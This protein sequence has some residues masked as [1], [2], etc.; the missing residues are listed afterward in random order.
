MPNIDFYL[1]YALYRECRI[2]SIIDPAGFVI[3]RLIMW[4]YS[5]WQLLTVNHRSI[6]HILPSFKCDTPWVSGPVTS[7][8]LTGPGATPVDIHRGL[9]VGRHFTGPVIKFHRG[10]YKISPGRLGTGQNLWENGAGKFTTG[11]CLI[12][13]EN[14]DPIS[15]ILRFFE[16]FTL[17]FIKISKLVI[18]DPHFRL[19]SLKMTWN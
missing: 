15:P 12:S 5:D 4:L 17:I 9:C 11:S 14:M 13:T 16:I 3:A 8:I 6:N 19:E 10:G 18:L 7:P 2:I 1:V